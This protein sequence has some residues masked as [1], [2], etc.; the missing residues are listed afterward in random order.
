MN[1]KTRQDGLGPSPTRPSP[2]AGDSNVDMILSVSGLMM[3]LSFTIVGLRIWVRHFMIKTL[4]IDDTVMIAA[5]IA[6]IGSMVCFIGECETGAGKHFWDVDFSLFPAF[7]RWQYIHGILLVVGI[8]LVKISI[9]FFLLRL[10]KHKWYRR[11]VVVMQVF[12]AMFTISCVC[13]LVFQCVPPDATFE[14]IRPPT[15]KCFDLVTFTNIG[16]FNGVVNITTDVAFVLLPI[17]MILKLQVNNRTKATLIFALS[18]G[19]FACIAA[20]VRVYLGVHV[21]ENDDYTCAELHAGILAASL[22]T[23][24]P[25]FKSLLETTSRHMRSHGYTYGSRGRKSGS[26]LGGG[27]GSSSTTGGIVTRHSTLR[28]AGYRR[29]SNAVDDMYALDM[30]EGLGRHKTSESSHG[31]GYNARIT[32][33]DTT[34]FG[35]GDSSE[36]CILPPPPANAITKRTEVVIQED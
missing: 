14:L 4:G 31:M 5:L 23:L 8:S 30:M 11:I 1:I 9:G 12:I 15:A 7:L 34:T 24:R 10:I 21:F 36:E 18:L 27:L 2:T 3:G 25:L 26:N 29:H 19:I 22:P 6:A 13:T 35:E 28:S 33:R 17:P 20:I 16:I 32:S